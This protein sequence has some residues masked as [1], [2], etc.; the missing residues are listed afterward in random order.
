M[1]IS[2]H[3]VRE[4]FISFLTDQSVLKNIEE[5]KKYYIDRGYNITFNKPFSLVIWLKQTFVFGEGYDILQ[6]L[7]DDEEYM[8]RVNTDK[9]CKSDECV[10]CLSIPPHVLFC[11]CGHIPI[12]EECDELNNNL[13]ICPICKTKNTIKRT[14]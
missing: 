8:V 4:R 10:I 6:D 11:V 13:G 7:P 2:L 12:C 5:C 9:T 3:T 1:K 14:I